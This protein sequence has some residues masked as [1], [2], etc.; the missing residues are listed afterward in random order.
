MWSSKI[1]LF[2]PEHY[3]KCTVRQFW[4]VYTTSVRYF[5]F[6]ACSVIDEKKRVL[7]HKF[8]SKLPNFLGFWILDF[9][10]WYLCITMYW[11]IDSTRPH[12]TWYIFL[13]F[14]LLALSL[15]RVLII[16]YNIENEMSLCACDE[17]FDIV[18][19]KMFLY[20]EI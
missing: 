8:I 7:L 11:Q 18:C 19:D 13:I 10:V 1:Q 3:P 2:W 4:K 9:E 12:K 16:C 20:P 14:E 17:I 5:I 15:I 6:L